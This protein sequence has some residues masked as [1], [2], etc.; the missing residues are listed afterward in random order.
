MVERECPDQRAG[1]GARRTGEARSRTQP[2]P[3]PP[4]PTA[5]ETTQLAVTRPYV[6]M[7]T[8]LARRQ[9]G[10]SA[11][12]LAEVGRL[13]ERTCMTHSVRSVYPPPGVAP[14]A[15]PVP[16]RASSSTTSSRARRCAGCRGGRANLGREPAWDCGCGADRSSYTRA[17]S[18][19]R[20]L[21]R[22]GRPAA[23][24]RFNRRTAVL[25]R[26]TVQQ[27]RRHRRCRIGMADHQP[28]LPRR[29]HHGPAHRA[30]TAGSSSRPGTDDGMI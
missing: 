8:G 10:D 16:R 9:A 14:P 20:T 6:H 29:S 3:T 1:I 27:V 5:W 26:A 17:R 24:R 21:P 18:Q 30:G 12:I 7:R 13:F 23:I 22:Q 28:P 11:V 19:V 4:P 15:A 25:G 2:R